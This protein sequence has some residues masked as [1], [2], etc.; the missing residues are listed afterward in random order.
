MGVC[1][2]EV[3]PISSA[4]SNFLSRRLKTVGSFKYF[5]LRRS[6]VARVE[7]GAKLLLVGEG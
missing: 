1:G 7:E 3:N 2:G 6:C 4:S 5:D